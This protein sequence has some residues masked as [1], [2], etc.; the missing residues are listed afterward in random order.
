[1]RFFS[2]GLAIGLHE[3]PSSFAEPFA[4]PV[5][6]KL[7]SAGGAVQLAVPPQARL[8]LAGVVL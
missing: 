3:V 2:Q 5:S 6:A 8:E 7:R 4:V 1:V